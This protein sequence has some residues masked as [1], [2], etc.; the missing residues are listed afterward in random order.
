MTQIVLTPEQTLQLSG[1]AEDPIVLLDASGKRIGQVTR[2]AG[3]V[4]AA[5]RIA[6]AKQRLTSETGGIT[7][8][9]LLAK[10]QSLGN[11]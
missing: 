1:V 11:S 6:V 7:T 2:E 10:L 9:D 4:F 5:A 8:A 3:V